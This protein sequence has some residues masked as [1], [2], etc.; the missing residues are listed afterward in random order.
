M[1]N[2]NGNQNDALSLNNIRVV[3]EFPSRE[4]YYN[5]Y[6][7][8]ENNNN[9]LPKNKN[10]IDEFDLEK[11]KRDEKYANDLLLQIKDNQNRRLLEKQRKEE[12]DAREE[13]RLRRENEELERKAE[14]ERNKIK[15]KQRN[16]QNNSD[17][18][19]IYEGN[20]IIRSNNNHIINIPNFEEGEIFDN[21]QRNIDE[22]KINKLEQ[23]E[24]ESRLQL[25]NEIIKLR[26]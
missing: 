2:N 22:E 6:N 14:E 8:N 26:Q 19:Q 13:E 10:N 23:I 4:D 16:I 12:E 25:N 11:I 1:K 24:I 18:I 3:E 7:N 9:N 21:N 17:N 5:M 20:R 15:E